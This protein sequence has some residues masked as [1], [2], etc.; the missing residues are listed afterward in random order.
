VKSEYNLVKVKLPTK[1]FHF[2]YA[3]NSTGISENTMEL[4]CN[5]GWQISFRIHSASSK[6]ETSMK[7]DVQLIGVPVD[8]PTFIG[9]I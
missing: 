8:I 3:D 7:F 5:N 6:I 9:I 4:I 1:I 2:D